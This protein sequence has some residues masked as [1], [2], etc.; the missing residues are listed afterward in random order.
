VRK[1]PN[2]KLLPGDLLCLKD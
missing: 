1:T 2:S